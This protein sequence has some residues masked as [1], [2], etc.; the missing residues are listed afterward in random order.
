[1]FQIDFLNW[2]KK[3]THEEKTLTNYKFYLIASWK[4]IWLISN[5]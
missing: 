1:M 4:L 5:R 2:N 3:E